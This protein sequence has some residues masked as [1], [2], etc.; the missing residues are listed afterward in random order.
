MSLILN[1]ESSTTVCS[2]A[3]ARNGQPLDFEEV[4]D[5][6]SHA[7]NLAVFVDELLKRNLLSGISK[8]IKP[9]DFIFKRLLLK[10]LLGLGRAFKLLRLIQA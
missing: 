2:V 3:L 8:G 5:G 7:E 1:I 10:L 4:N 6:Y 9:L